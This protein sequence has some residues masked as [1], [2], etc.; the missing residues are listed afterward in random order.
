MLSKILNFYITV[1]NVLEIFLLSTDM[2]KY[3]YHLLSIVS[4]NCVNK[5]IM[6][7]CII[8]HL[9]QSVR[10]LSCGDVYMLLL[11]SVCF[12][13]FRVILRPSVHELLFCKRDSTAF[14]L[15]HPLPFMNWPR[16]L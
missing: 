15:L 5:E 11:G 4:A 2:G 6:C 3:W 7:G 14:W 1:E 8:L 9:L 13:G 16:N 10:L 12:Y